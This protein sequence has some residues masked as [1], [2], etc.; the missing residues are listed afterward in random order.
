MS[1]SALTKEMQKL[2]KELKSLK[3][4][5][6]KTDKAL[7]TYNKLFNKLYLDYELTPKGALKYTQEL[8]L[9]LFD[10]ITNVC[11]KHD[12][13]YWLDCGSALGAKR[14]GGYVPWDDD[15]DISML[16]K[17]YMKF[18]EIID[19]EIK[20]NKLED[21]VTS[22]E[23]EIFNKNVKAFMSVSIKS[24]YGLFGAVDIFPMDYIVE[25]PEDI[26]KRYAE[27]RTKFNEDILNDK[28]KEESMKEVY[29]KLNLTLDKQEHFIVGVDTPKGRV[30]SPRIIKN[31]RVFPLS[32][33]KFEDRTYPCPN[34]LDYYLTQIYGEDYKKIPQTLHFHNRL[35]KLKENEGFEEEFEK[36]IKKI[37][38]VNVNF[39]K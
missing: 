30:N 29:E 2:N 24:P 1:A 11:E 38:E 21:I 35:E 23:C 33:V 27:V 7:K 32:T 10:F 19:G 9:Q 39:K 26:K 25:I 34:N 14:H 16:R 36:Y 37:K 20:Q 12:I 8:C 22:D 17:D 28:N 6:R 15:I 31:D 18:K 13:T 5:Q 3:K 4:K